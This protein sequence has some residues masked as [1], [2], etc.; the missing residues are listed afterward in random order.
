MTSYERTPATFH[1]HGQGFSTLVLFIDTG[2]IAQDMTDIHAYALN[3]E[4][5][6]KYTEVLV[7][8]FLFSFK[9]NPTIYSIGRESCKVSTFEHEGITA[10]N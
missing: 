2:V 9:K 10:N 6:S 4:T 8:V 3:E 1:A 5:V 7:N